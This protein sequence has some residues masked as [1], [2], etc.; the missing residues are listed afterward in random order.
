LGWLA[1]QGFKWLK[2]GWDALPCAVNS[3]PADT[4]VHVKPDEAKAKDASLGKSALKPIGD[5]NLGDEVLAFSEWK[6][7]GKS[8]KMDRRLSYEKV[9]DVYT[10]HKAQ[11]IVHLTLDDGQT[12]TATEGHP[13]KT[14][15]GWRDAIM[16][17]KGGQLLLKGDGEPPKTGGAQAGNIATIADVSTETRI[18]KV[19]NLE[20]ANAHTYFVGKNAILVHNGCW[21]SDRKKYWRK[22]GPNGKPPQREVRVKDRRT[23]REY[24]RIETKELHHIDP[25]RNNGSNQANNLKEVW[26]TEH[27]AIDPYRHTGYDIIEAY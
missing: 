12:L 25:Q 3:F 23:G 20:V 8:G 18:V 11:T 4:L 5:I 16:L 9:T 1:G 22:N 15:D 6:D 13:F 24:D 27:E 17:K 14:A 19:F 21:K 10:S 26:P 7:R 2:R